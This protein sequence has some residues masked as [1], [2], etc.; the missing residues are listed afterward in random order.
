MQFYNYIWIKL[1]G[2]NNKLKSVFYKSIQTGVY[3]FPFMDKFPKHRIPVSGLSSYLV[4]LLDAGSVV[5]VRKS[6]KGQDVHLLRPK[7][8]WWWNVSPAENAAST[9]TETHSGVCLVILVVCIR[10]IC[11]TTTLCTPFI[12]FKLFSASSLGLSY[13]GLTLVSVICSLD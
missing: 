11:W 9:W 3:S 2:T 8:Y 13:R 6:R 4:F 7:I 10:S 1:T 12:P 5:Q